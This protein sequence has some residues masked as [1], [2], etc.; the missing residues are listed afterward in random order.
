MPADVATNVYHL[1]L[2][3]LPTIMRWPSRQKSHFSCKDIVNIGTQRLSRGLKEG[4]FTK[5]PSKSTLLQSEPSRAKKQR[6]PKQPAYYNLLINGFN[7]KLQG[8]IT[9]IKGLDDINADES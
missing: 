3:L 1:V 4:Q 2:E 8:H 6:I 5:P 9:I 7:A